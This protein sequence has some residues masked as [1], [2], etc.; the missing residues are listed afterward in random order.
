MKV[1]VALIERSPIG[2]RAQ[3]RVPAISSRNM[4]VMAAVE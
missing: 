1:M 4:K 3:N 2:T